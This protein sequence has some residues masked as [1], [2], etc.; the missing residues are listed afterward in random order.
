MNLFDWIR[1]HVNWSWSDKGCK[2]QLT[3]RTHTI[4]TCNHLTG[5]ANLMDFHNYTVIIK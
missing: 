5:F 3:N 1:R 4:C 2:L